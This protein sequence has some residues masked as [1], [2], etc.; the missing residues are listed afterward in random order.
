MGKLLKCIL[1]VVSGLIVFFGLYIPLFYFV[2]GLV[3]LGTT[4]F[5]FGGTGTYQI[6]YY[7][8][9]GICCLAAVII[10]IRNLL[11]RPLSH[12]FAP[13]KEYREERRREREREDRERGRDDRR[14]YDDRDRRDYDDRRD[15]RRDYDD[16]RDSRYDSDDDYYDRRDPRDDYRRDYPPRRAYADDYEPYERQG[17]RPPYRYEG[18]DQRDEYYDGRYEDPRGRS[19]EPERP[20]IY[21]SNRRPGVLVKEYSDRFELF[22]ED[23]TGRRYIGTEYKDE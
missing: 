13:I 6:L 21:Y 18:R 22:R 12:V 9:L 8:G 17:P 1:Q 4:D 15:Y 20:L 10:S 19:Y 14:D 2:F 5:Q 3:L 23:A 7:V 11:V 16:R